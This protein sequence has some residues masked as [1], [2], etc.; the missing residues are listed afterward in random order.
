MN[1]LYKIKIEEPIEIELCLHLCQFIDAIESTIHSLMPN[2]LTEYLFKLANIFNI[3]F[4]E[5]KVIGTF[6]ESSRLLICEITSTIMEQGFSLLG[7]KSI[8]QM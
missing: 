3:F 1:N 6:E 8:D 4:N 5:C 7:L 2:K